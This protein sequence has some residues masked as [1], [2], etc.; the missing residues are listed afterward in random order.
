MYM[1]S[2][3]KKVLGL[4]GHRIHTVKAKEQ[5]TIGTFVVLPFET[6]HDAEEPLGY[7]IY[8][9]A[10]EEKLLFAT[11]TYYVRY[12]FLGLTHIMVECNY[13][14]DI[15]YSNIETGRVPAALKDRLLQSH[16][17]LENVKG[18]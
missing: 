5:F 7:L 13:I 14:T 11:D 17:S 9:T 2:G 1:S 15:L 16:F 6:E 4:P 12:R 8:S 18:F 10:T 3:S